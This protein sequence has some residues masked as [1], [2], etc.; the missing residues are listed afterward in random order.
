MCG[1]AGKVSVESRVTE[2]E[3]HRAADAIQH[4]GPDDAGIYINEAQ[5]CGLAHRRLSLLDLSDAGHQPMTDV[6]G[7]VHIVFNGEIYNYPDLKLALTNAGFHFKTGTD[8]EAI[9]LGYQA[10]GIAV[11][12]KLKG[13]FAFAIL[14]ETKQQL[15]LA[16]DRFGIKPL[17]YAVQGAQ[18]FFGSELKAIRAMDSFNSQ[19]RKASIG[20]FLANRYV[21]GNYTMWQDIRQ[22]G[23]GQYLLVNTQTLAYE[24]KNYWTLSTTIRTDV[25][26]VD[27]HFGEQLLQSVSGHLLSDVQVGAF[28]SGGFDSSAM[29]ALMQTALKYS[30]TAFSI[31][32][33][34]WKESEHRYAQMVAEHCGAELK[35][36]LLDKIDLEIMPTLMYH[37]DD[38]IADISILPTYAVSGLASQHV[39]AVLSGEG[40]DELLG[41]Y[42][43][44]KPEHFFAGKPWQRWWRQLS[45]ISKKD[46]KAHYIHAMSMGLYDRSEIKA[47]L[48]PEWDAAQDNDPF[49][50]F[51]GLM[52]DELSVLKQ[53]QYLDIHTFMG[54]LILKKVDRASMAHSLEVR[55]PF[56]DHEL[57]E[58]LFTLPE[59]SYFQKGV[60][61]PLLRRLLS[62]YVP[63]GIL[64][65]PKQ[66]FVGPDVFY[67]D[68]GLYKKALLGGR[69]MN[70]GVIRPEYLETLLQ[71]KEHWKLWKLFVLEHWWRVW[72]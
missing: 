2:M 1:I 33:E 31:G 59:Q 8:T 12:Q 49:A 22:L 10:W 14:D 55:V 65:R 70:E 45:G 57:A 69:L 23:A 21:A 38:P 68:F 13:M 60:Q 54:E 16:R 27:K 37:Y 62:D 43:W 20:S 26:E 24:L 4:R 47:A 61:K 52:R 53:I 17:Y 66:G 34:G 63:P 41:G 5:T 6:S 36:L 67:M 46:I 58:W 11:L 40:A 29:V 48:Q 30:T 9:L 15:L 64:D 7:K 56:L 3:L 44:Q 71:R 39:K 28:L 35:T 25:R 51:D 32:F 42:W 18:L 50:H 19:I 72:V